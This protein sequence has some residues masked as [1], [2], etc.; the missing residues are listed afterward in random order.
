MRIGIGVTEKDR[1]E[2]YERT[3]VEIRKYMPDGAKLVIVDDGSAIP[4]PDA[5]FRFEQTVGINNAKNKCLELLDD[6]DEIFLFDSDCFPLC[7]DWWKPYIESEE[8]HLNYIFI[9]Y[10]NEREVGDSHLLYKDSKIEAFTHPRGCMLYLNHKCLDIVGGM[11]TRYKAWGVEHLDL[12]NRIFNSG[13]TSF[14][15]MDVPNSDKLIFSLDE[16]LEVTSTVDLATRR[17]YLNEVRP[18]MDA[19][20]MS[21]KYC[22]YKPEAKKQFKNNIILT[23]YFTGMDDTQGRGSLETDFNMLSELIKS[24]GNQKLVILH[25]CFDDVTPPKNVELIKVETYLNPY[26]QRWISYYK[27]LRD[28]PC[29]AV[30]ITDSTDVEM[31]RNPF[32]TID[33]KHIYTGDEPVK[34]LCQWMMNHHKP[35]FLTNFIRQGRNTDLLNAGILGGSYDNVLEFVHQM[36]R[37]YSDERANVGQTDMGLFNYVARHEMP[38]L[39]DYGRHISTIFKSFDKTNETSL[40]RHK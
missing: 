31:L 2:V 33:D 11:E 29:D 16:Q 7:F 12:S 25:N 20:Y 14:R 26:F 10:I 6:C 36:V 15:Y 22:P 40:W 5:T 17:K 27:Y 8:P 34:L 13:L 32:E 35:A 23:S 19:S 18:I 21:K 28:N 39:L 24:V 4:V 38:K 3:M 30:W 1:P 9:R 37:I